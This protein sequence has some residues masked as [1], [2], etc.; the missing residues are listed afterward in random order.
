MSARPFLKKTAHEKMCGMHSSYIIGKLL[1]NT[2][3]KTD[4]LKTF[5][6]NIVFTRH[7]IFDVPKYSVWYVNRIC[8]IFTML[9]SVCLSDA[10]RDV[11]K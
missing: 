7:N 4:L 1:E 11:N 9:N 5:S 2:I 10:H 8:Q 3:F 6:V